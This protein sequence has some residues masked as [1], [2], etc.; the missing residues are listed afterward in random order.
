MVLRINNITLLVVQ[1]TKINQT[2]RIPT[3][4]W[5]HTCTVVGNKLYLFGGTGVRLYN[6]VNVFNSG[7]L[8]LTS[9]I[10]F[11][12]DSHSWTTLKQDDSSFPSARFGKNNL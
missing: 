6:D 9:T 1:S 2:G 7:M 5:G 8:K 4:R 3:A 11:V 10:D 12:I